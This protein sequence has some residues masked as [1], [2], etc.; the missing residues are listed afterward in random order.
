MESVTDPPFS[1][2]IETGSSSQPPVTVKRSLTQP[3]VLG[4]PL[5]G[6]MF[7]PVFVSSLHGQLSVLVIV[8]KITVFASVLVMN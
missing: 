6:T 4:I 5:V 3:P 2:F 8:L 7:L 1:Y